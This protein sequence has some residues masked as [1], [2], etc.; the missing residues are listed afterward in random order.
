MPVE[1]VSED[2]P[3]GRHQ[4]GNRPVGDKRSTCPV[5]KQPYQGTNE[6]PQ[7]EHNGVEVGA[8]EAVDDIVMRHIR[9]GDFEEWMAEKIGY[10]TKVEDANKP[11]VR[12]AVAEYVRRVLAEDGLKL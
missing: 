1:Y 9:K 4:R 12:R 7:C 11:D 8:A 2:R 6:C 5:C 3:P 10:S